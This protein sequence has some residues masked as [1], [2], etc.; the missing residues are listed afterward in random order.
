M[1][2]PASGQKRSAKLMQHTV[3]PKELERIKEVAI[4]LYVEKGS[5]D[6]AWAWVEAVG[7]YLFNKGFNDETGKDPKK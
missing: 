1:D 4:R 3:S 2:R 5:T 7:E 6:V